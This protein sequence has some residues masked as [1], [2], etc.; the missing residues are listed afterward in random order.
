MRI[1]PPA[2]EMPHLQRQV[3][4]LQR[5]WTLSEVLPK[6]RDRRHNRSQS[7]GRRG[8]EQ[9]Q[10]PIHE[11]SGYCTENEADDHESEGETYAK[12]PKNTRTHCVTKSIPTSTSYA[13][14]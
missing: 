1:N 3:Q 6:E 11:L 13:L 4:L 14:I 9:P 12:S 10:K 2:A 5:N 8:R 7:R